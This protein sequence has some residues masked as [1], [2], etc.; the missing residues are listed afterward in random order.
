M[1]EELIEIHETPFRRYLRSLSI[2]FRRRIE[3]GLWMILLVTVMG[4]IGLGIAKAESLAEV[5][6]LGSSAG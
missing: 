4:I 2:P 6:S 1:I 5:H 3:A